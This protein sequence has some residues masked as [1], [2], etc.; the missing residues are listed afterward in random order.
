MS[1]GANVISFYLDL[2]F[3]K[4]KEKEKLKIRTYLMNEL[5]TTL[6]VEKLRL[7][8]LCQRLVREVQHT[9]KSALFLAMSKVG[10]S[11]HCK[12]IKKRWMQL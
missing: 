10:L 2:A 4:E 8:W 3:I 6:F 9:E 12:D 11:A 1:R 7:H 5:M